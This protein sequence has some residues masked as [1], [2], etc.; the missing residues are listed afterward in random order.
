MCVKII[1]LM[2]HFNCLLTLRIMCVMLDLFSSIHALLYLSNVLF[3]FMSLAIITWFV[4]CNHYFA[5]CS[6]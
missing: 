5:S 4:Y 1:Y 3:F 6:D 2:Q